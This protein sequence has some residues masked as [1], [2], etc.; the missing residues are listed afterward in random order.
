MN[1]QP[2]QFGNAILMMSL[3]GYV[4]AEPELGK[5]DTGGQVVYVLELAKQFSRLGYTVDLIT[6][7][8]EDQPEFDEVNDYFRIWRIPFGGREFIRKEDMHD[9]LDEFVT[10]CL[11]AVRNRGRQYGVV[12]SHYW[13]AGWAGQKVADE[14]NILH[15]HTPTRW[16]GGNATIW[17]V[18]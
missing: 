17:P 5:P 11:L 15:V 1:Q 12:Y 2:G 7:R 9:H 16:A 10:N 6:R 8:F 3:H 14:L 18:R 13:D 4:A